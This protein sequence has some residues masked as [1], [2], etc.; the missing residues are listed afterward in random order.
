VRAHGVVVEDTDD[1]PN[2]AELTAWLG[3][4][5]LDHAALDVLG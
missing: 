1:V 4:R 2:V 3:S 5:R